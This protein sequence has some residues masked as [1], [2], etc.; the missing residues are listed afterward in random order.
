MRV[1]IK[2]QPSTIK[3]CNFM[4]GYMYM[5]N[6]LYP[7]QRKWERKIRKEKWWTQKR[8]ADSFW[9]CLVWYVFNELLFCVIVYIWVKYFFTLNINVEPCN[10]WAFVLN[11]VWCMVNAVSVYQKQNRNKKIIDEYKAQKHFYT[12][13]KLAMWRLAQY[14]NAYYMQTYEIIS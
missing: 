3:K 10:H 7:K 9:K 1:R 4:R 11:V 12:W 2:K 13:C 14:R 8:T 5:V 6:W